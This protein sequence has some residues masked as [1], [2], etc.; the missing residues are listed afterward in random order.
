MKHLIDM[1][2]ADHTNA[3]SDSSKRSESARLRS[4]GDLLGQ[5]A[6]TVWKAL[7]ARQQ[8]PYTR[9]TTWTR[10]CAF[11]TWAIDNGHAPGPNPYQAFRRKNAKLFKHAYQRK[12]PDVTFQEALARIARIQD[13]DTRGKALDLL[14][15][16]MRYAESFTFNGREVVGKG[17]KP[18]RVYLSQ[19]AGAHYSASYRT[20]LNR[21]KQATGLKPH[22]LRKIALN[23][24]LKNGARIEQLQE[25]AGWSSMTTASSYV[26]ARDEEVQA[27]VLKAQGGASSEANEVPESISS[28]AS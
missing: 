2:L 23:N 22:D 27:L 1:Y 21:L 11:T 28:R 16:G 9:V 5:P 14:K 24:F 15:S 3:W 8:K 17:G 20:F 4:L 6:D 13:E 10:L 25:I 19:P 18:R 26:K 12:I 7:M